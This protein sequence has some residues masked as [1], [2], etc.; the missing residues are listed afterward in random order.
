MSRPSNESKDAR[1]DVSGAGPSNL[2]VPHEAVNASAEIALSEPLGDSLAVLPPA[3]EHNKATASIAGNGTD[4][5]LI[6]TSCQQ[7]AHV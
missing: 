2:A 1:D 3:H 6:C 4:A 7:G 5:D